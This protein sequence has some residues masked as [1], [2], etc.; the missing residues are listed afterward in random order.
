MAHI[1]KTHG[2]NMF[3]CGNT[4]LTCLVIMESFM[5]WRGKVYCWAL[6]IYLNS[7]LQVLKN[8]HVRTS[9]NGHWTGHILKSTTLYWLPKN[10]SRVYGFSFLM[11]WFFVIKAILNAHQIFMSHCYSVLDRFCHEFRLCV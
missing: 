8:K 11:F 9:S 3:P 10:L 4:E 6:L 5:V 1:S 7:E 2:I